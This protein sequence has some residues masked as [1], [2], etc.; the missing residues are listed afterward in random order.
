M[1]QGHHLQVHAIGRKFL[2]GYLG[3][4]QGLLAVF[5]AELFSLTLV[6]PL[7]GLPRSQ[8]LPVSSSVS[9]EAILVEGRSDFRHTRSFCKTR[10]Q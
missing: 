1:C 9:L 4:R 5:E 10:P 6:V 8:V 3:G 7:D 2:R